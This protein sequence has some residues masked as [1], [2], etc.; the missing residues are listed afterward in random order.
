MKVMQAKSNGA[1]EERLGWAGAECKAKK[2]TVKGRAGGLYIA[3]LVT[4]S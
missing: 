4:R 1:N 2:Q 3:I